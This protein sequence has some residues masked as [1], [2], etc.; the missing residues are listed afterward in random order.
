MEQWQSGGGGGKA[1]PDGAIDNNVKEE[2]F[3]LHSFSIKS[4]LIRT[5]V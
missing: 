4:F 2:V 1:A 5:R 3:D